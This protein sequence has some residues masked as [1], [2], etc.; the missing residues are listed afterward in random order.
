M[1]KELYLA[2]VRELQAVEGIRHIDLWNHNV[3]F[4]DQEEAWERP[5]VFVEFV[6]IKWEAIA[7]GVEYRSPTAE[8]RLHVVTDWAGASSAGSEF[9]EA[10]LA[11]F[12]LCQQIH[13]RLCGLSGEK[14]KR[15]DLVQSDT[16]HNHEDIVEHIETYQF[17][18]FERL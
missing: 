9:Q 10:A 14:F 2:L 15:L 11:P 1:R 18:A 8:V 4:L 7:R 13:H 17:V 12:D 6:P 3:E 5:A 16:N